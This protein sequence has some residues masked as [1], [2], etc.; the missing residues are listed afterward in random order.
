MGDHILPRHHTVQTW[1]TQLQPVIVVASVEDSETEA[2]EAGAA[3]IGVGGA[4]TAAGD[5]A[6]ARRRR[7][8]SQSPS[9]D[10][11]SRTA[12]S[13][14]SRRSTSSLCPLRSTRSLTSSLDLP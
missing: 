7:N 14:P 9:L 4:E 11:W 13:S 5:V 1:R 10:V 8:G 6:G 12:R 3:V 2:G